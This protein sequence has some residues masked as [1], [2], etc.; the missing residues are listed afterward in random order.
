MMLRAAP[1]RAPAGQVSFV[2]ANMGWRVHELVI[3]PLAPDRSAGQR[4]PRSDGRVDESGHLGE[5]SASCRAGAGDGLRPGTV[6]WVTVSLPRGH[7]ELVCNL[8]HHYGNGMWQAFT[9]T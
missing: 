2:V 8:P 6:G 4:A 1:D 9:V 5:A 3:L 7:Y